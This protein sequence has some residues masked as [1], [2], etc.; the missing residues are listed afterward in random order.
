MQIYLTLIH[1]A[2]H[3]Q[4]YTNRFH[5]DTQTQHIHANALLHK[6]NSR[7]QAVTQTL[8]LCKLASVKLRVNANQRCEK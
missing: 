8:T 4:L 3:T 2:T 5:T 1:L 7:R 6:T